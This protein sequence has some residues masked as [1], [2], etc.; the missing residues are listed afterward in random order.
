MFLISEVVVESVTNRL[1]L[2]YTIQVFIK[3]Y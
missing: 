3:K 2:Q 1:N